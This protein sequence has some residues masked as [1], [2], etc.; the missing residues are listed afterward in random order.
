MMPMMT[1]PI[2]T[3]AGGD[4]VRADARASGGLM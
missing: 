3:A 2:A 1:M 4:V